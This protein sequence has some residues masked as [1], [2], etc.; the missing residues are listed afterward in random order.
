MKLFV[1]DVDGTLVH[2]RCKVAKETIDAINNRLRNGD[3]VAIAS[4]RPFLGI[5]KYLDLFCDG[6]K[7]IIASNGAATYDNNKKL[8]DIKPIKYKDYVNFY[9][10][11]SYLID[12]Y[13]A[14]IYCYTLDSV[15]YFK[16]T[17][18]TKYE[19]ICNGNIRLQNLKKEPLKESDPLLKIML[20]CDPKYIRKLD[21][22]EEMKNMTKVNSSD[23]YHE[24]VNKKTDKSVGVE[25]LR[26]KFKLK[27]EDCYCFGDQ[28]NDYLM[29]KNYHGVAMGNSVKEVIKVAKIVTK[30]DKE[31]GVAY[32]LN[33]LID[34]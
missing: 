13:N 32:A 12:K 6:K 22:K 24:F 27:K 10:K 11:Y 5:K 19:S 15:G 8:L 4:G 18:N 25:F 29:I 33:N 17:Y 2:Y 14:S 20:A 34:K 31:K 28:M 3:I 9:E 30:S 23:T 26:K 7:Y 1:F 16:M 21:F